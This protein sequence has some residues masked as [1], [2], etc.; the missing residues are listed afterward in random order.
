MAP[1]SY[2]RVVAA[3]FLEKAASR[4]ARPLRAFA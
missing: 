2:N 4:Q 1:F 3:M